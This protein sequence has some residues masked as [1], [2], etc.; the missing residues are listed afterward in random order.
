VPAHFEVMPMKLRVPA[1][2]GAALL[3]LSTSGCGPADRAA[4]PTTD[5]RLALSRVVLYRNGV[6]YFERTGA[7]DGDVL[8]LKVRKDQINDLLKSLTIV[9]RKSGQALSVSMPLDPS[10]WAN[11]ALAALAPGG[12]GNLARV[13]DLLRGV[14]IALDTA[15]RGAVAGRIVMI[16]Q[17]VNEPDPGG[18]GG[19]RAPGAEDSAGPRIDHR[20]TLIHD[21]ELRVVRLSKVRG[22]TLRDGDLALQFHRRL[23]ATAGEGMFQQVE[24]AI[25]LHG[26]AEHDLVVS[27]V[28][29]APMWKPTYRVVLPEGGKGDALLQA[30]AVVDNTSGEDW[31]NVRLSVTA[32]APIAFR[33]DLHTPQDVER[34]DLTEQGTARR[35][36]AALGETSFDP[37]APPPAPPP[38]PEPAAEEAMKAEAA[39]VAGGYALAP[40]ALP[41]GAAAPASPRP[42]AASGFGKKADM[43]RMARRSRPADGRDAALDEDKPAETVSIATLQRSTRAQARAAQ[44]SG[45]TRF[46][47]AQPVTVPDGSATMVALVNQLVQGEETFLFKPGGAGEGYEQSPYRVVRFRN[48]TPFVLETGPIAIYAGGSFVG[49][50]ISQ[51]VG[52][53]SSVTVPFAVEGGIMV[54]R[55]DD[56]LPEELRL[57]KIVRGTIVCERFS[58]TKSV[59]TA[60]AQTMNKGFTVFVRHPRTGSSYQLK[61]RPDGTED[62]PDAYLV[63]LRVAPG[64]LKGSVEIVEQT[65]ARIQLGVYDVRVPALFEQLLLTG[66]LGPEERK[67]LEPIVQLRAEIGRIDTE[68]EGLRRQQRELDER[69]ARTRENLRAIEKDKSPDAAK[70]RRELEQRL[71]EFTKDGDRHGREIVKLESAR[72]QKQIQLDDQ[73]QGLTF[74]APAPAKK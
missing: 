37:T 35:A 30:W 49:E 38:P 13:L 62:L 60:Q 71:D 15:D 69:G 11:A 48:V 34:E 58:R 70:L 25:R 53:Q 26:A 19:T 51:T 50:G 65:P 42:G 63:P 22:I 73:L 24:V 18:R 67:K 64:Q 8:R 3:A 44:A 56:A 1:R 6:G 39:G 4:Y 59:W 55:D 61:Q 27:Y 47:I 33:Y 45:L 16:E 43:A 72:L 36:R 5:Q 12:G 41:V 46:D 10:T 21:Q 57:V 2:F 32:G 17:T 29:P 9:D 23:D 68:V 54:T 52:S 40:S 7:V 31:R 14:D 20:V 28:V 74:E 66:G